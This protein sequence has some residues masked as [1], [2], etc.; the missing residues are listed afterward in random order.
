MMCDGAMAYISIVACLEPHA[1]NK[2]LLRAN[3]RQQPVAYSAII[4]ANMAA[5]LTIGKFALYL[6]IKR[7]LYIF[8]SKIM[9][10]LVF[11]TEELGEISLR[12]R[13]K[14]KTYSFFYAL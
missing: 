11:R 13:G 8:G 10:F 2:N 3:T 12:K 4:F 7:R 9:S 14:I 6:Q 1:N 5:I